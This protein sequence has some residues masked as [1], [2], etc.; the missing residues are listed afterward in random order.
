MNNKDFYRTKQALLCCIID[1]IGQIED[2]IKDLNDLEAMA[3]DGDV[4]ELLPLE[5]AT[6]ELRNE[7]DFLYDAVAPMVRS[8]QIAH[9]ATA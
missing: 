4:E 5:V 6:A 1:N 7:V 9:K 2:M 3:V 8:V